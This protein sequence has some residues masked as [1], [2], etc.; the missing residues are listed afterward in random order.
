[1]IVCR[2]CGQRNDPSTEFCTS[3]S[4]YLEWDGAP[5]QPEPAPVP[6]PPEGPAAG[7][8][9]P[10]G[11]P[12]AATT[13]GKARCLECGATN[14]PGNRFCR[15]CGATVDLV[16]LAGPST[17]PPPPTAPPPPPPPPSQGRAPAPPPPPPP[18]PRRPAERGEGHQ[19][20]L[21][22]TAPAP[23]RPEAVDAPLPPGGA[24]CPQ[25]GVG[26]EPD[27]RFCRRCGQPFASAAPTGPVAT[28]A[29]RP[30]W[31]RRLRGRGD[32]AAPSARA[33]YR[34][35]LDVRFRVLRVLAVVATLGMGAGLLG[36]SGINP[37]EQARDL[38][39]RVFPRDE[40]VTDVTATADPVAAEQREFAA[41]AAVD[42]APDTAWGATWTRAP[43]D[44]TEPVPACA[45]DPGT[46]G[47]DAALVL[48]L[49]EATELSTL[50]VRAGLPQGDPD[51]ENQWRPT[52]L[53]L[54]YDDGS[55]EAIELAA[56]PGPQRHSIDAPSTATVRLTVLAAAP[57]PSG[58]GTLTTL[59]EVRLLHPT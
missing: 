33:A 22:P 30:S 15:R 48:T 31:W 11:A 58:T 23:Q 39:K 2:R 43:G 26:N 8:G 29:P 47:A 32:G 54:R 57:P 37:V 55:C 50:E 51:R 59:A 36:V 1:M 34:R 16:V 5:S 25:C 45:P 7:W 17:I 49:P 3:C 27:R 4:A 44:D 20:T 42:G 10:T 6:P 53:E 46:G 13:P 56:D 24:A 12:Q 21:V 19:P 18:P 35:T 52:L 28:P 40:P 9:P 14:E 41:G 38:W